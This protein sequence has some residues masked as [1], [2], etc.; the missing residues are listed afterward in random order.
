MERSRSPRF[1]QRSTVAL[2]PWEHSAVFG[3][4]FSSSWLG[5]R[6]WAPSGERPP[7][8]PPYTGGPTTETVW[9]RTSPVQRLRRPVQQLPVTP[10]SRRLGRPGLRAATAD[11]GLRWPPLPAVR[12]W[13]CRPAEPSSDPPTAG[14]SPP[15]GHF[16]G[17]SKGI[18]CSSSVCPRR[19]WVSVHH[20]GDRRA[21]QVL[22]VHTPPFLLDS[23]VNRLCPS[24][25]FRLC[26]Q[27]TRAGN[28]A[29]LCRKSSWAE[30]KAA[31]SP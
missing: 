25:S 9:P 19:D 15:P 20:G 28:S 17:H 4:S 16:W 31:L 24:P 14:G 23:Q 27:R 3:G 29:T 21:Q 1:T 6:Q 5:R 11:S 10:M 22:H 2:P 7:N 26:F 13:L 8:T 18:V 12:S 30:P